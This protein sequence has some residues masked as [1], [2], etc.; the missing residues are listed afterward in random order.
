M[1]LCRCPIEFLGARAFAHSVS[2]PHELCDL[3]KRG[4]ICRA[5]ASLLVSA[6][7]LPGG[8]HIHPESNQVRQKVVTDSGHMATSA[9]A[10][11]DGKDRSGS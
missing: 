2:S 5:S 10:A 6:E 11:T 1:L 3:W 9:L 4:G 7:L 8:R